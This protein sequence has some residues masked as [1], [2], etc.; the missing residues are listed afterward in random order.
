MPIRSPIA[1]VLGHVD[2][3]KTTLLDK[4]RGTSVAAREPGQITQWIGASLIPAQTITR[5][6]GPLLTRFNLKIEV[7]GILF[8]D[9]PGHETFS[10]L[11]KRGGS[12]AD[13]AV[14]VID[15][16]KGIE[17]QTVES[18]N[19]LKARKTP[20]LVC[21]NKIDA[22]PGW[23]SSPD[24]SF[25]ANTEQQR[26]E[27]LTDLDN[28]IYTMMGTLS[29]YSFRADRFDRIKDFS[30][31]I[32]LVP[33][34][35]KT[36]EGLP[37][38]MAML[39]GLTQ[40]FMKGEL[41]TG[42]GP[43]EGTVL[44]VKEEPGLGVTIDAMIYDGTI[45]VDDEI[46]L[47]G[48]NGIVRTRVRALL[49]P[50]ALDEI[51]DPRD[52]FARVEHVDA[53]AGIKIAAQGLDDAIAGS[54]IYGVDDQSKRAELERKVL[55]EVESV[56]VSTDRTGVIVK[57]DALGSL[58]ALTTSL[59]VSKVPVRLADVGEISRRDVVEAE[60][61]RAKDPYL[62]A[63][64][65]FNVKLLPDA[66]QEI[67]ETGIPVFRGDIIYRVLEDYSRW[68]EAQRAA[69]VKVVFRRNDPAIVGV[70]V[71]EGI[72][73]PKYPVI[74]GSGKRI[75]VLLRVQDQGKDVPEVGAGKQVAVS[76]DKP[77]VGRHIFE[78]DILYVDVP[79]K[80]AKT[81]SSKF[82]D[83]LSP[84]ELGLLEELASIS[85]KNALGVVS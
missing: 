31:T 41:T 35:A 47:A 25:L 2:H 14:L 34:S 78:G 64:L 79:P 59:S 73:R 67:K 82:R 15:L 53:A 81:L 29:R 77:V 26:P 19:I 65:G 36:G 10:N 42:A 1:V 16:T 4:I 43:A 18:L 3:G 5:I 8:I 30:K 66:E 50:K 61:V 20:F 46:V 83:Y 17:P 56:K 51:R 52:K 32:A 11:R 12:A 6:C 74:N 68:V 9:T 48:R 70:E 45:K 72:V 69:G 55:S 37:E 57:A 71:L 54:P 40:I 33:A 63:I 62:A 58:E 76:I 44:E 80:H 7:P 84:G 85:A 24:G 38:L 75:G 28:R 27:V 49:L 21:C 60:V 22:I 13:V 39:V 23:K